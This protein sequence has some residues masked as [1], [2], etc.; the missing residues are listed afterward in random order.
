MEL[1]LDL[2]LFFIIGL[3]S[4]VMSGTFGIGGGS[5]RIP[6]L[7]VAGFPLITAYGTNLFVIPFSSAMGVYT[8]QKNVNWDF[9]PYIILGGIFGSLLGAVFAGFL[10]PVFLAF[11]FVGVSILTVLGINLSQIHPELA[12]KIEPTRV[13]IVGGT[14]FLNF[15]TGIRGGSGGSLF[16]AFLKTM[17]VDIREAIATSLVATIFTASVAILVYWYRGNI[18]LWPSITV[19]FG[20]VIGSRLG[21]QITLKVKPKWLE[22]GLSVLVIVLSLIVLI[23]TLF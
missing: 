16:P 11:T 9:A 17:K 21:S 8:Q 15:L 1:L 14:F 6:L 18:D 2:T 5:I 23:K 20:S 22:I 4:G 7:N 19:L 3:V 10:D 12:D 13:N